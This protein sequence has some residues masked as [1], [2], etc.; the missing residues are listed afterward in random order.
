[1]LLSMMLLSVVV[2]LRLSQ[3]DVVNGIVVVLVRYDG[4]VVG[5]A[6]VVV[7]RVMLFR[8]LC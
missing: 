6:T 7:F 8:Y 5:V 2:L 3:P 1:M 4:V